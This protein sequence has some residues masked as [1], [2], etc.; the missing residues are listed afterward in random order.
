M[1]DHAHIRTPVHVFYLHITTLAHLY[2]CTP[3]S[4]STL[5]SLESLHICTSAPAH[6]YLWTKA[7]RALASYHLHLQLHLDVLLQV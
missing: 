2:T 5:E 1:L 4:S 7:E 3:F 6:V